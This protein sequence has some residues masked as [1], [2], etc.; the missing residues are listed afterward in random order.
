M[1]LATHRLP[2]LVVT[3]HQ[4]AVPL[5]HAHPARGEITVFA[6]EVVAPR[7]REQDL[8]WLLLLQGGPGSRA[9]RPTGR[10]GWLGRALLDH[11][12]LLCSTSGAPAG[13]PR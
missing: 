1:Q 12:V 2:G 4:L 5:D 9:P 3:E 13:P 10:S 6:R 7:K 11:R 8:P